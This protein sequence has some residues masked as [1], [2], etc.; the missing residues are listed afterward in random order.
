MDL[1]DIKR[2]GFLAGRRKAVVLTVTLAGAVAT[3]AVGDTDL[4]GLVTTIA[5]ILL[6][7]G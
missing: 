7:G 5:Q 3:W 2:G 1:N 4:S 6:L